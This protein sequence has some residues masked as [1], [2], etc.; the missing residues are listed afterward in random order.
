M[1]VYIKTENIRQ[2]TTKEKL[3]N[4]RF[5]DPSTDREITLAY[6]RPENSDECE[7]ALDNIMGTKYEYPKYSEKEGI[8][9]VHGVE[10]YLER[11]TRWYI[12]EIPDKVFDSVYSKISKSEDFAD[13]PGGAAV[14]EFG[15]VE[16]DSITRK[17]LR[18]LLMNIPKAKSGL[19]A[20]KT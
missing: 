11:A 9:C 13:R 15:R 12:E 2:R 1:K 6:K 5:L 16:A 19:K 3:Y 4:V 17:E 14:I 20:R 8:A 10:P 7:W 18:S